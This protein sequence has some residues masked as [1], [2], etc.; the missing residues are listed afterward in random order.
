MNRQT[1]KALDRQIMKTLEQDA[2]IRSMLDNDAYKFAMQQ[3]V[4]HRYNGAEAVIEFHCRNDEDLTPYIPAIREQVAAVAAMRFTAD[5]L[6]YLNSIRF[7][8]KDYTTHLTHFQLDAKHVNVMNKGGKLAIEIRGPWSSIIM[9]E[10]MIMAIISEIRNRIVYPE[11]TLDDARKRIF[12]KVEALEVLMRDEDMTGFHIAD[13][14]T[15]RRFSFDTQ[16]MVSDFMAHALP[17]IFVGTSNYHIARE[18]KLTPI[19]TQAH[20]WFQAHQALGG[21]R[22]VDFQKAALEA[23]VQEY[24]GDLGIALTDCISMDAFM[25]DFDMYFGKLFDGV[26][27]DSGDP[28]IW[29]EKAIKMYQDLHIDPSSKTLVFSDGLTLEKSLEIFRHFRGRAKTSFGI[30]TSLSCDIEG[31]KP[32]NMVLK[33]T[34][35]EG[36]P[37]AKLSDSPGKTMCRNESFLNYLKETF[38]YKL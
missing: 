26:R 25:R 16:F 38:K 22:L 29:G 7:I 35:C 3:A 32:M 15:R 33:M 1:M 21:S 28:I 27:H 5:Q 8:K 12:Q 23:W 13:F 18:L 34:S 20:E 6:W 10:V 14:G 37:T 9:W 17:N 19:G 24:R 11:K 31:V 2:I 36:Q 4:I 30:G